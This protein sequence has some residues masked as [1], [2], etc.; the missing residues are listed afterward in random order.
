MTMCIC[1][2]LYILIVINSYISFSLSLSFFTSHTLSPWTSCNL[3]SISKIWYSFFFPLW[4]V[5]HIRYC[6]VGLFLSLRFSIFIALFLSCIIIILGL[7]YNRRGYRTVNSSL[8][9]SVTTISTEFNLTSPFHYTWSN[10]ETRDGGQ[11]GR[12]V[13]RELK[14]H[15]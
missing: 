8:F 12:D 2:Y 4:R 13:P 14:I 5:P 10:G 6:Q 9:L 15:R 11:A 1:I 7:I 3:H